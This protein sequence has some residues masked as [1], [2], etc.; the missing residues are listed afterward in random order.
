MEALMNQTCDEGLKL[1]SRVFIIL[2]KIILN[3]M[4]KLNQSV[5]KEKCFSKAKRKTTG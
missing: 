1:S 3:P 2:V 5:L 4:H